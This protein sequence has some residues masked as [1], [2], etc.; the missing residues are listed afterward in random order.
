MMKP[1]V[2][3]AFTLNQSS[4]SDYFTA[5]SNKFHFEDYHVVVF[6]KKQND[7]K[8]LNTAIEICF[9]PSK[10]P[11]TIKDF[12]FAYKKMKHYKPVMAVSIF[13]SVNVFV[14]AGYLSKVRYRIA[15]VR[16]LSTQFVNQSRLLIFRKSLVYKLANQIIAN[17]NATKEDVQSTYKVKGNKIKVLPNSVKNYNLYNN[18][19]YEDNKIIYVGRLHSS[20][21]VDVLIKAVSE[22]VN[23]NFDIHL[24]IIGTGIEKDNLSELTNKLNLSERIHFLG[25]K[26][27]PEVLSAFK[28]SYCAVIPS[29]SEAFGFT[30]IEAMSV[31]TCVIG[32][33]NTGIK[34][35]IINNQ[36][37]LLFETDN[38][39]D[40]AAKI[41]S[42]LIDEKYRNELANNGFERFLSHYETESVINRDFEYFS[43]LI[44]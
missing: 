12:W 9:W 21:G 18:A 40:L 10:R 23:Q 24:D 32:A 35:I 37:G 30:V 4:V 13:G 42:I 15:W 38:Y 19:D 6:T 26:S 41:K 29:R 22:L 5:L 16:T 25:G 17:S 34:E 7:I 31:G 2:F 20:K 3:I 8:N 39:Q 14:L 11:T 1:V 27:K 28:T 43:K 44:K 36:T 33:N